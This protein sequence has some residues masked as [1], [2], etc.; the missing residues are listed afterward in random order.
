MSTA[1]SSDLLAA[2]TTTVV[3]NGSYLNSLQ[4]LTDGTNAA[5]VTVFNNT[6]GSGVVVAKIIVPGASSYNGISFRNPIRCDIGI[7]VVVSGTGAGAIVTHSA[8]G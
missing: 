8:R 6:A 1:I 5:T 3:A 7:T 2:G 4:V